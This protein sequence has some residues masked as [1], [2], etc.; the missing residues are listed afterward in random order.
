MQSA[1]S[2]KVSPYEE[3]WTPKCLCY[4]GLIC[5]TLALKGREPKRYVAEISQVLRML[6]NPEITNF[7]IFVR[8]GSVTDE[9]EAKILSVGT[10]PLSGAL[11]K[12]ELEL[13]PAPIPRKTA[14]PA[15][16]RKRPDTK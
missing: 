10:H 13:V 1:S 4:R 2:L 6:E 15:R 9:L 5:A 3:G 11:I 12:L 8:S 14:K 7:K 16:R